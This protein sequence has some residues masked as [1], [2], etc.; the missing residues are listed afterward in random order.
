MLKTIVLS[1]ITAILFLVFGCADNPADQKPVLP[2]TEKLSSEDEAFLDTLQHRSFQYFLKEINRANG[3]VRDRSTADAPASIAATGFAL[4]VWAVGAERGWISRRQ[5]AELTI[6]C[7]NFLWNAEHSADSLANGYR[8]FFYHFLKMDSGKRTWNC[9][10][11]S[12]DTA[13]LLAGARFSAQYFHRNNPLE[14]QIRALAD[15]MTFRVDWNWMT[16]PDRGKYAG[17]ISLGWRPEKGFIPIGWVG[18]NEALILYIIAA[19]SG[20]ENAAKAYQ[21]WL[22]FYDWR[23]PYP[24]MGLVSFPPL[25]GHQYSHLFVD[26]RGL[27]DAYM[28]KKGIDYFENSRRAVW[29]QRQY[30]IENPNGWTGYDSLCWGL[31]ACD[32]PGPDYNFD[33]R[34]FFWYNARGASGPDLVQ[35]DDGTI[36][37][38]AAAASIA[39]APEIVIPTLKSLYKRYG[40]RGLWGPYGF[41]DAFNPTINWFDKDYLGIDQA[42]VV[43]MIENYRSGMIWEYCMRDPVI[44]KGLKVLGFK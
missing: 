27:P 29:V 21:K 22:S 20:Y 8:G 41:R 30:A 43:L 15:S 26:F 36:A 16:L 5:A 9:E 7:L 12:I 1:G 25:F 18:Y 38:T 44:Q 23:E 6:T 40:D 39:F 2:K 14:K 19:G 37:P 35:N 28:R 13:L 3:L 17:T 11:S 32:G 24:G 4:P 34:E 10:L 31:T 33:Q 42:P